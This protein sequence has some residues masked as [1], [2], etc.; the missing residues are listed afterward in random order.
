SPM[1]ETEQNNYKLVNMNRL[2][3][4]KILIAEDND[5]FR[6]F[7]SQELGKYYVI[8]EASDGGRAYQQALT[9]EP[10]LILSDMM[11]PNV[12]GITLCQQIKNNIKTC[13]TP[14]VLLT[15]RMSD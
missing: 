9:E 11:M 3:T 13:H 10:D 8:L 4:K 7:L 5:E 2:Q 14:I 15:A 1:E 12:D 6:A